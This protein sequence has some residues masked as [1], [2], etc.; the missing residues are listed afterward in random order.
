MC[1]LQVVQNHKI[2]MFVNTLTNHWEIKPSFKI[3]EEANAS[4]N[5]FRNVDTTAP[6]GDGLKSICL[7]QM[8][9]IGQKY[10]LNLKCG[11]K[12]VYGLHC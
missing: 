1:L 10:V 12:K 2:N 4:L 9:A 5:F 6:S 3:V 8:A 11:F 7:S